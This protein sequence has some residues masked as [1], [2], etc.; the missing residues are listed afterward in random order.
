MSPEP[1]TVSSQA[2]GPCGFAS[3]TLSQ[4]TRMNVNG[5][6]ARIQPIV[7]PIRTIPNSFESFILAKAIELVIEMVGTYSRQCTSI[8]PKNGQNS[9][10]YAR[11]NIA[12]PP[13][14]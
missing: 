8:R 9:L 12:R 10:V 7:P 14:R 6:A 5:Q 1:S 4:S 11:P 2:T 3:R 13:T